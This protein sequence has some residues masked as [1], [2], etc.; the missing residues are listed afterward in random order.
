MCVCV[1]AYAC[2]CICVYAVSALDAPLVLQALDTPLTI[3]PHHADGEVAKPESDDLN[4]SAAAAAA[5][6]GAGI[7]GIGGGGVLSQDLDDASGVL[8]VCVS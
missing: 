1:C 2:I 6:S 8:A 4:T 7:N 5:G 3:I